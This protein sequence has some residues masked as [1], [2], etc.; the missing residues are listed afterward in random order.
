MS[1]PQSS[2]ESEEIE[3]EEASSDISSEEANSSSA[4]DSDD[5]GSDSELEEAFVEALTSERAAEGAPDRWPLAP[6][7][8]PCS[9]QA[10]RFITWHTLQASA[11]QN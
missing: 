10:R 1:E 6:F 7:G 5:S 2:S 4:Q 8:L 9:L 11:G 3:D